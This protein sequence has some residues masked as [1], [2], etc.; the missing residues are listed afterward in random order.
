MFKNLF[1]DNKIEVEFTDAGTCELIA[2]SVM[3]PADLPETFELNTTLSLQ[4]QEW[5]VTEAD[6]V[7]SK[8]FIESGSLKLKLQ[9]IAKVDP[10]N[11]L[12]T[13]PTI[14]NEFPI[15]A[16]RSAFDNFRTNF[17]EDDWRQESF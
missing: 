7:H 13:L 1:N 8:D 5:A 12:Y 6:P 16:D 4:G 11:I 9:K 10:H 15:I 3:K 2:R 14:S 17:Y